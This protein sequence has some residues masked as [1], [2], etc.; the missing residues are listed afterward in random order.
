MPAL[1]ENAK[2]GEVAGFIL[3]KV[4]IYWSTVWIVRA[5]PSLLEVESVTALTKLKRNLF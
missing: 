4:L 3:R 2:F 1:E 5:S